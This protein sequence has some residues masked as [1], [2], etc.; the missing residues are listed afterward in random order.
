LGL[1]LAICAAGWL[2]PSATPLHSAQVAALPADIS[3][4]YQCQGR[5][6]DGD[7]YAGTVVISKVGEVYTIQWDVTFVN[8]QTRSQYKGVGIL[9]DNVF[10]ANWEGGNLAGVM[11]YRLAPSGVLT[12]RWTI[13]G[14]RDTRSE[15]L[16]PAN[17]R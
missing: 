6:F 12:G 4:R 10:S 9:T 2:G 11:A 7:S 14:N 17:A 16:T 15:V 8:R 13:S 3:G 5:D 1:A